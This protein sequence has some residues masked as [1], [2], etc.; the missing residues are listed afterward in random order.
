AELKR[1]VVEKCAQVRAETR[2]PEHA[3]GPISKSFFTAAENG[4]WRGVF[5]GLTAMRQSAREGQS[6]SSGSRL[7]VVY[8]VEWAVVNEIGAALEE[9]AGSEEKYAI[10]FARDIISSI[11]PGS[12][13]FGGTDSGRFLVTALS[14][15]HVNA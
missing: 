13:Y 4:D 2:A 15:S 12:I 1:F 3:M 5:D 7:T 9:F 11:P 6:S 14:R 8:P 10:A